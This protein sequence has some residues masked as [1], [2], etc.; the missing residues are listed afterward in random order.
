MP[1]AFLNLLM[2]DMNAMMRWQWDDSVPMRLQERWGDV[3]LS[4]G[5]HGYACYVL[6]V[7]Y[8]CST[9]VLCRSYTG[10]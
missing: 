2:N 6:Y 8:L 4:M 7:T 1:N 5:A 3:S 10:E 9:V